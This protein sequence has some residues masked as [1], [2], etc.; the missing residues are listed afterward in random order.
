MSLTVSAIVPVKDG[1]RYLGEVLAALRREGVD[2]ILVIDSGSRDGSLQIAREAGARVEQIAAGDFG[3]GRTR[4]LAAELA[5]GDVLAFLTQD[6]TPALGWLA[7]HRAALELDPRVGASFGPH[8]PRPDTSPMIAR[9][10]TEFFASFAPDGA[11]SLQ[12]AGDEPFLSNVNTAYRRACWSELRFRDVAY[13][14]DQA[15]GRDL[16]AAGWLKAYHPGAGVLHA[17]DYSTAE[18]MRRYFDE[19]RGL[20]ETAGHVEAFSPRA[21]AR[22]TAGAV[23]ADLAWL[24]EHGGSSGA[25]V[26]LAPRSL[27]HH[28]G[29][30]VFS[31]LGSRAPSLPPA[32]QRALSLERRDGRPGGVEVAVE[33]PST[34]R[35]E[36]VPGR[37]HPLQTIVELRRDGPAPLLRPVPGMSARE[38]LRV[39]VVIPPF[40]RGSGGHRT[41][42]T[43]VRELERMGHTCS[44][45]LDDPGGVHRGQ[46][47]A[48]LRRHVDDWFGPVAAPVHGGFGAW[49]GADV[50][51]A[52]GW[53]T[54]DRTLLLG[55]VRARAYLVQDH[56]PEFYAT[57]VE[58]VLAERTYARGLYVVAASTWLAALVRERY[59]A[60]AASFDLGVDPAT[61]HPVPGVARQP[62]TVLF[63]SRPATPRRATTLGWLAL[64]ELRR[65]RPQVRVV[66]FGDAQRSHE[67]T[68]AYDHAGIVE[69]HGLAALYSQGTVGLVLS[70]TN[71]SLIPQEMLACGMPCV[72]LLG[73][74][75]E[76]VFGGDGPVAL[77]ALD[78]LAVADVVERLLDDEDEW[79]RRS[80]AGL[81]WTRERTWPAAA[82]AFERGLRAAL[83]EREAQ[84]A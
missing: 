3:H 60:H 48:L 24:R 21:A 55:D 75:S 84:L 74:C 34:V 25:A 61:Y 29:R 14:E 6:A 5:T 66:G 68:F 65:R 43:L 67:A 2:E 69:P 77:T 8:L 11:P 52:T 28:G 81:A 36:P 45:W 70:L 78:P 17:H 19:Y 44:L 50:V 57:S 82:A 53:Q 46:G 72:D 37:E 71:Y 54:V 13:A 18:F 16:L 49:R 59:G 39:A 40:T 73:G 23:R 10:L 20:R 7:A 58:R 80:Q 30:R 12:R 47:D 56:E 33:A 76:A 27:A 15:F 32:L 9:E 79:R 26:A 1:R 4:N 35:V 38:R 22:A 83:A 62:D 51:V 31:A 41:I 42:C 63:Y 64:A